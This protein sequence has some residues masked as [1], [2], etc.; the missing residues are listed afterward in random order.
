MATS[1]LLSLK[2]KYHNYK[3]Y[4]TKEREQNTELKFEIILKN[5]NR[6]Y[7]HVDY[8]FNNVIPI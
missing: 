8:T 4:P 1:I 2:T 7:S 3:I 6:L 5:H